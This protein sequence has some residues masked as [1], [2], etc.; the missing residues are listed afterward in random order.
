MAQGG[1]KAFGLANFFPSKL[2]TVVSEVSKDREPR[3]TFHL[4]YYSPC[5][6][7]L[8]WK[9]LAVWK[10]LE[11]DVAELSRVGGMDDKDVWLLCA[12]KAYV[13]ERRRRA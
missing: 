11:E 12:K 2:S 6:L 8:R 3:V 10:E 7:K 1:A 9:Q 13:P 5:L 4:S